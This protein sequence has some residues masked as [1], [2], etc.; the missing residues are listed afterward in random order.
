MS[1]S[2]KKTAWCGDSGKKCMRKVAN[3]VVRS[4]LKK[5]PDCISNHGNAYR[6]L[7]PSWEI[8]DYG[9]LCTWEKYWTMELEYQARGC[10]FAHKSKEEA[11]RSWIK[12]YRNK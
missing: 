10:R 9:W 8:C 1:R 7:F 3:N 5:Y 6:R 2:Y 11:F 4:K 12:Y